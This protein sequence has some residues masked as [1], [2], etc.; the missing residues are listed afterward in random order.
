MLPPHTRFLLWLMVQP[1]EFFRSGRGTAGGIPE[2]ASA[3]KIGER[4]VAQGLTRCA[5]S[6]QHGDPAQSRLWPL[7]CCELG[8]TYEQEEKVRQQQKRLLSNSHAWAERQRLAIVTLQLDQLQRA[9]HTC[10]ARVAARHDAVRRIL[11]PAQS[12]RYLAWLQRNRERIAHAD[13]SRPHAAAAAPSAEGAAA[14]ASEQALED[15]LAK[16]CE[17]MSLDDITNLLG[18]LQVPRAFRAPPSSGDEAEP[19]FAWRLLLLAPTTTT[20]R[21]R[22]PPPT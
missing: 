22:R 14:A 3:S 17:Q 13:E 5:A 4:M 1:D 19:A 16:P 21:S 20:P 9:L 18:H 15:L 2:R 6:P 11:T 7:L 8:L 12:V 10:A